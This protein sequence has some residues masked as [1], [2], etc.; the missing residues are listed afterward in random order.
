[1]TLTSVWWWNQISEPGSGS[2]TIDS[3]GP[4]GQT[5]EGGLYFLPAFPKNLF[6]CW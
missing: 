6:L 5:A 1:M 4:S 3:T 2:M